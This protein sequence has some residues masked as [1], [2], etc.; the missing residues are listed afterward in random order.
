MNMPV[1]LG[2]GTFDMTQFTQYDNYNSPVDTALPA[3]ALNAKTPA[4]QGV[5][6]PSVFGYTH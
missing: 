3:E 6:F 1:S 4:K 2:R 5:S